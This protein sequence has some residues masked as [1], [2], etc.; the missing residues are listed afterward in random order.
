MSYIDIPKEVNFRDI[1]NNNFNLCTQG[2]KNLL[3]K[4]KNFKLLETLLD[5]EMVSGKEVGS[6]G[7]VDKSDYIFVRTKSIQPCVSILDF[8]TK[9][10]V[11]N[12]KPKEFVS[13]V[14]EG[15]FR[16]I[17]KGD[18]LFVTGGNVGEVAFAQEDFPCAIISS[19]ILKLSISENKFYVFAFLKSSFSKEQANFS[20]K[21]AIQ[22]LDTFD[23]N[24]LLKVKIP[25]PNGKK[26]LDIIR[27]VE[28]L[29]KASINKELEIQRKHKRILSLIDEELVNNQK[30]KQ[31]KYEFPDLV[32]LKNAARMDTNLFTYDFKIQEYKIKNYQNGFSFIDSL[33]FE[34][35]RGQNLQ[36]STIGKSI[37]SD[38]HFPSFYTLMLPKHLS[39]HGTVE[40]VE[41]LGN[42]RKLK[43]LKRGDLIF[44]A[45]GFEKGRS[46]VVL[47]EK[48]KTITNIHGITLHH[49]GKN[50]TLSIFVKCFLDYLRDI[51]LIDLYAV[52]G[53]G[54]S[55]AMKYWNVIP[56]PNFPIS[57]QEEIS[58]A[59]HNPK[60]KLNTNK[61]TVDNFVNQDGIFNEIAGI[62]MNLT[63]H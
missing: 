26:S 12:I 49:N 40:T 22:G 10:A 55:L 53:N 6:L 36:I 7:Y 43:T 9:G 50:I 38:K 56:F 46:I 51:G 24:F 45:E 27:Y 13:N 25:F 18:I 54:G 23:K 41:Y 63:K 3:L 30:Q 16:A 20:P 37:Y 57:K 31:P 61:L 60:A 17:Q 19:H 58:G 21:G 35:F 28:E 4:N 62:K 32:E 11:Q 52:G 48:S 29:T 2:Y 8:E 1:V 14:G 39:K 15:N 42:K 34:I 47:D 59:Y 5:K 33:N 44:G